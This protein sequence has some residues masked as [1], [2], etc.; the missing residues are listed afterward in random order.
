MNTGP[1]SKAQYTMDPDEKDFPKVTTE[2]K[3]ATT[4]QAKR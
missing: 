4:H 3:T 1:Q 2:V